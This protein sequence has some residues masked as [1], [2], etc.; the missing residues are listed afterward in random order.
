M[1]TPHDA[2]TGPVLWRWT[3]TDAER[4]ANHARYGDMAEE[5][6]VEACP[7]AADGLVLWAKFHSEWTANPWGSRPVIAMLL[8]ENDAAKAVLRLLAESVGADAADEVFDAAT[9]RD[10][11]LDGMHKWQQAMIVR[12]S[13]LMDENRALR[14]WVDQLETETD[15]ANAERDRLA[16]E[17]AA[18]RCRVAELEGGGK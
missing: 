5:Y 10:K 8:A 17:N 4:A 2:P 15:E 14:R 18:L 6:V 7:E 9:F 11:I 13:E 1:T 3:P 12:Q 16:A